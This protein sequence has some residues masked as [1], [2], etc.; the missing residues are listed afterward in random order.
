MNATRWHSL[1]EFIKHLGREGDVIAEETEKGW[2]ITWIDRD[3]EVLRRQ[4]ILE[5]RERLEKDEEQRQAEA[6]Q[7]QMER[8][9]EAAAAR[10]EGPDRVL[11]EFKRKGDEDVVTF[12]MASKKPRVDSATGQSAAE[13]AATFKA[14]SRAA[15]AAASFSASKDG[16]KRKQETRK[17][18]AL[19]LIREVSPAS[20][21]SVVAL[22]LH[23]L[24]L[25][26]QE[27][28][29]K[30]AAIAEKA[31]AEAAA[32]AAAE[33]AAAGDR[34]DHWLYEGIVVK[35]MH[36]EL[37]SGRYYKRKG[38][39]K[40]LVDN[41]TAKV[42]LLDSSTVLKLDQEYLETVIPAAGGSVLVVN[43]PFRGIEGVLDS[44]DFDNFLASITLRQPK[45]GTSCIQ[46]AY[47]DFCKL[48]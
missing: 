17:M 6:I 3:P 23:C 32:V 36:K 1:T 45:N 35:V 21:A 20:H 10:G 30:K 31:A 28:E 4:K 18:S 12:A 16:S 39:V 47:E 29:R 11:E 44:V 5:R 26:H 34:K 15:V 42:A 46:L 25:G 40:E 27:E 7:A 13:A 19:E 48:G 22:P 24:T 38:V 9:K 41:Y 43:G 33:Q 2:Y 8:D 14:S 37:K